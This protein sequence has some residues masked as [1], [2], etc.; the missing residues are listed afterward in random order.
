[1]KPLLLILTLAL[2]AC[3][4]PQGDTPQKYDPQHGWN[5]GVGKARATTSPMIP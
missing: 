5:F 2:C 4:S 1:M 3:R